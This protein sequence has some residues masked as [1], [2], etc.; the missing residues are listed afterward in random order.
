[1]IVI[2]SWR[3]GYPNQVVEVAAS[4]LKIFLVDKPTYQTIEKY[5]WLTIIMDTYSRYITGY[6]LSFEPPS[7]KTTLRAL[8]LAK[9]PKTWLKEKLPKVKNDWLAKG[10]PDSMIAS[11]RVKA[12]LACATYGIQIVQS[13][14]RSAA[15]FFNTINTEILNTLS[16]AVY[17]YTGKTPEKKAMKDAVF[18][19][20]V[21]EEI[22]LL[23]LIDLYHMSWHSGVNGTP[24]M[25]YAE[26]VKVKP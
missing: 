4:Q 20:D 13:A 24:Q 10:I 22:F 3:R 14:P 5:P 26:G 12:E 23:W 25:I 6:Y 17:R 8:E 2:F 18:S 19:L 11:K 9:E 1:M 15:R 21:L 7:S 16:G